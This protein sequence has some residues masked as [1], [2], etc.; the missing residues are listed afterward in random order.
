MINNKSISKYSKSKF[1]IT[2]NIVVTLILVVAG[3]LS[4]KMVANHNVSSGEYGIVIWLV[5]ILALVSC[6]IS[7]ITLINTKKWLLV[8]VPV[9]CLLIALAVL[10]WEIF[11][12]SFTP[13]WPWFDSNSGITF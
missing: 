12:L 11:V 3:I 4:D 2:Q 1:W 5:V 6:I 8:F 13:Y 7:C 9:I 10:L